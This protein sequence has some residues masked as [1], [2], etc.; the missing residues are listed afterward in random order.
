[1]ARSWKGRNRQ[2]R[3]PRLPARGQRAGAG[4][5]EVDRTPDCQPVGGRISFVIAGPPKTSTPPTKTTPARAPGKRGSV[6]AQ[7][8]QQTP[9]TVAP[10][11]PGNVQRASVI[12]HGTLL[13]WC[14]HSRA[15]EVP[16]NTHDHRASF[17]REVAVCFFAL[18]CSVV[19]LRSC[20][21]QLFPRSPPG[22]RCL[23]FILN[24]GLWVPST[25]AK[26]FQVK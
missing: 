22:F 21:P 20:V 13:H 16:K 24:P 5:R 17:L 12:N 9:R 1:V 23:P 25:S 2:R 18:C 14:A 10:S 26:H 3:S 8:G 11:G 15:N 6:G 7:P 4:K 19:C